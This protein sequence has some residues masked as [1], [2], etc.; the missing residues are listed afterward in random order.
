MQQLAVSISDVRQLREETLLGF[1]IGL[2]I[3]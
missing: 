3:I 2:K 1:K